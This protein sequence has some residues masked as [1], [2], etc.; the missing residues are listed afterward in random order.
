MNIL[1]KANNIVYLRTE[2]K[3]LTASVTRWLVFQ[4]LA[5]CQQW[6]FAKSVKM[7]PFRLN[8]SPSTI[9]SY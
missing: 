9:M 7:Y 5:I 6:K 4:Y 1:E 3:P 2:E 8:I